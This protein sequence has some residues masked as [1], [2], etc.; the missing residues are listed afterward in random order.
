MIC[1]FLEVT[2]NY[3]FFKDIYNKYFIKF[4]TAN[5]IAFLSLIKIVDIHLKR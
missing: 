2:S 5:D 4:A 1:D 3:L